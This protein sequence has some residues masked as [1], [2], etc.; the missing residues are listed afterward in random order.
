M[1]GFRLGLGSIAEHEI[2]VVGER[3]H[4]TPISRRVV[5]GILRI[6][7]LLTLSVTSLIKG[8][9]PASASNPCGAAYLF[10]HSCPQATN[11]TSAHDNSNGRPLTFQR[12]LNALDRVLPGSCEL[13]GLVQT[14]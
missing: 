10:Y 3:L 7:E 2:E 13:T 4:I 1:A 11:R 12:I 14:E 8:L 6:M 9:Y 5:Q